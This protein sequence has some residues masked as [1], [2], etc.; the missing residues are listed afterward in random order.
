MLL[1]SNLLSGSFL[2]FK[3]LSRK[4]PCFCRKIASSCLETS[5]ASLWKLSKQLSERFPSYYLEISQAFQP[6]KF[7]SSCLE[8]FQAFLLPGSFSCFRLEASLRKIHK[9]LSGNFASCCLE[10]FQASVESYPNSVF[11]LP[12]PLLEAFQA[13]SKSFSSFLRYGSVACFCFFCF[14]SFCQE[15]TLALFGIFKASVLKLFKL[16]SGSYCPEA[17]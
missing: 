8:A 15:A 13:L 10:A 9:L 16:L 14:P 17:S 5:Q 12:K 7:P 6:R 2:S 3:V 11:K 1:I 4:F